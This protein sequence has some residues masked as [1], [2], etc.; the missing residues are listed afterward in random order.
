MP[1]GA[2]PAGICGSVHAPG[3]ETGAKFR[4]KTSTVPLATSAASNSGPALAVVVMAKP[5]NT[6]PDGVV[7]PGPPVG[8]SSTTKLVPPDHAAISPGDWV[9]PMESEDTMKNAGEPDMPPTGNAGLADDAVG[10]NT[11]PVGFPPG[12]GSVNC[13]ITGLPCTPP[14]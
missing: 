5:L 1:N 9:A 2:K 3:A 7:P 10:L 8:L 14:L 11:W 13:N 6:A 12:T 4:S